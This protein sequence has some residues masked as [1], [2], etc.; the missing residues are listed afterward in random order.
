MSGLL[1]LFLGGSDG[2]TLPGH[3]LPQIG[4]GGL[5]YS[6]KVELTSYKIK[7]LLERKILYDGKIERV[8]IVKIPDIETNKKNEHLLRLLEEHF[9]SEVQVNVQ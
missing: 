5:C 3:G 7:T 8:Q 1:T 6:L 2:R 9:H 4:S